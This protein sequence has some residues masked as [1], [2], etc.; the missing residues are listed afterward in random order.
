MQAR[1]A[2]SCGCERSCTRARREDDEDFGTQSW[3]RTLPWIRNLTRCAIG[4][5]W[6]HHTGQDETRGYGAPK[7]REWQVDIVALMED[8][9]HPESDIA[10]KLT[11]KKARERNPDDR[12]DFEP[13]VITLAGDKWLSGEEEGN[14]EPGSQTS[15]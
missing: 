7:K 2:A 15:R 3:Q 12:A 1:S 6:L 10:F 13:T 11:F 14:R 9:E 8:A 5:L 4:Q